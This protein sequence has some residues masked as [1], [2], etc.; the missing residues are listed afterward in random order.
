MSHAD[1]FAVRGRLLFGTH[2]DAATLVVENGVIARIARG[3]ER[4]GDLPA[5]VLDADI[6]SP[7]MID[8]QV[9]GAF[10]VEVGPNAADIDAIS[11]GLLATG[12]T[13]WLPTVVTAPADFY[14][15][16]FAAWREIDTARGAVPLGWHLEGPFL[17]P[18]KKGAHRLEC[19]EAASDE[20]FDSWLAQEG[21]ALVTLAPDRAGATERIRRLVERGILVSLGHTNAT[22]EE[23]VAGVDAGARKATHLF[24]AM[25]AIHHRAPG[26]MVAT[27]VDDRVTAGLIPDGV[28]SH[29]ATVR[30][31]LKS[32]G[33]DGIVI[34]SD[35]MSACGLGPGTYTLSTKVVT[36][37][38]TSARLADGTL[39]GSI[40]TMDEA[41]RNL[42]DWSEATP[43]QALH[44]ATAVPARLLGD[45][46]RGRLVAGARADLTFWSRDLRVERTIIGGRIGWEAGAGTGS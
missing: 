17:S 41:M 36:V 22:Y 45:D 5:T 2:L 31:A 20:L 42:V 3:L 33:P 37:D 25:T 38:E 30:L 29:P 11:V 10:G 43:A 13:A 28:H 26:A 7:G 6:V 19:I 27:M 32:K 34:V 14:P 12:V 23:F 4:D 18:E 9:N 1:T 44:M 24:N 15:P 35:M 16:V 39:A 8:L 46:T 21:I 40:L